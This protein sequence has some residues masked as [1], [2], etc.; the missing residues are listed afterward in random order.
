MC[1]VLYIYIYIQYNYSMIYIYICM[2]LKV[3]PQALGREEVRERAV[4]AD[5]KVAAEPVPS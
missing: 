3:R 1:Y 4:A 5:V 2:C